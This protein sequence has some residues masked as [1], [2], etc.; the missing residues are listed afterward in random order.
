MTYDVML[1]MCVIPCYV[2]ICNA[3]WSH[4]MNVCD[5]SR[6]KYYS[7]MIH[8]CTMT[9]MKGKTKWFLLYAM[10]LNY[11][12]FI[13]VMCIRIFPRYVMLVQ[14]HTFDNFVHHHIMWAFHSVVSSD[15]LACLARWSQT[16]GYVY[17][18]VC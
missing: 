17:E 7:Y 15:A 14:T 18:S 1:W 6:D 3:M 16:Q 10:I 11:Y 5:I 2:M 13:N 4:V 12:A 8:M 9:W